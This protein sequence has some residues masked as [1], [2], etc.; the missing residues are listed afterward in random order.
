MMYHL[1]PHAARR[2]EERDLPVAALAAAL[3]GRIF[4]QMNGYIMCIDPATRVGV[5]VDP[6]RR[7]IVTAYQLLKKQI[8]AKYSK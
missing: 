8:K 2:I 3:E 4:R 7:E 1:R 5:V 6:Y